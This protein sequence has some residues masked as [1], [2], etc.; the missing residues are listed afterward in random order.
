DQIGVADR[1]RMVVIADS[2]RSRCEKV[3]RERKAI[4]L[5]QSAVH[6]T[7]EDRMLSRLL[8]IDLADELMVVFL[9]WAAPGYETTIVRRRN[10]ACQNFSRDERGHLA[11][12]RRV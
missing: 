6:E 7:S 11:V 5:A 12:N 3:F 4:G 9:T 1:V 2:D 10:L 8:V